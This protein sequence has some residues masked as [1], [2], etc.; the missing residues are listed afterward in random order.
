MRAAKDQQQRTDFLYGP[1]KQQ[2]RAGVTSERRRAMMQSSKEVQARLTQRTTPDSSSV[3]I[4][5]ALPEQ[6]RHRSGRA[7]ERQVAR[8]RQHGT[9][10][11]VIAGASCR[12]DALR[13]LGMLPLLSGFPATGCS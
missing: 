7:V 1:R 5:A 3:R 10:G 11:I 12:A 6:L 9:D 4:V 2:C 8:D 13:H